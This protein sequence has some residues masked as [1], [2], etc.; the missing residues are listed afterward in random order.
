MYASTFYLAC[1]EAEHWKETVGREIPVMP[2]L[3]TLKLYYCELSSEGLKVI[4]DSCPVL[5]T[6]HI[7]GYFDKREMDKELSMKCARVKNLTLPTRI[8]ADI[9]PALLDLGF[10]P[11]A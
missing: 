9:N 4:L 11:S 10:L 5:E 1:N 2:K 6:L 3:H 8:S 7:D